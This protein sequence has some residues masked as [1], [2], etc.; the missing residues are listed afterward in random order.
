MA[1]LL[2]WSRAYTGRL[3]NYDTSTLI[4]RS[5]ELAT[6]LADELKAG[7]L[8][9]LTQPYRAKFEADLAK[10][11][12]AITQFKHM[13]LLGIGGSALGCRAIQTA[14]APAQDLPG[15]PEHAVWVMDNVAAEQLEAMLTA[16][17]PK[18]TV[19]VVIS[20]SGGTIETIAQYFLVKDWLQAALGDAWTKQMVVV[21]DA[22]KGYL[23][24]EATTYNLYNLEVPDYLGG[25]Y[26]ALSAVGLL[27][28]A[29]LGIDWQAL[30]NGAYQVAKPL[31]EDPRKNLRQHPAFA[32]ATWAKALMDHNYSQL[33]FFSYIPQWAMYGPWFA[34][35]WAE[36]LGKQGQGSQPVTATGVTDQ[37]SINQMFLD[38]QRDKG[39]LFLTSR[40]LQQGRSF[41]Q[42]LPD[43]WAYLKG[44]PFASLLEAEAL[45]TQMALCA[46]G[47]P[48]VQLDMEDT[49]PSQAGAMMMLLEAA[50]I[51]T[52]WLMGINPVDQPAVELGKRLANSR[53]G[54]PGYTQEAADLQAFLGVPKQEQAF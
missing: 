33:I 43:K 5:D 17:N 53:L 14:F 31:V 35:L 42:N 4:A 24:T 37:H 32:L 44:K 50:T 34:Q 28:A 36:S 30:L 39:C 49:G 20:K 2:E 12:P 52:G 47:V 54:A 11:L 29:Y 7:I 41:G 15:D 25:R 22:V 46:S 18:E 27:P 10:V 45:G 3:A 1:N 19:V 9:F 6:R 48:L 40:K 8:P 38:G 23:R 16:L 26:S 13:L 21:T 51:F